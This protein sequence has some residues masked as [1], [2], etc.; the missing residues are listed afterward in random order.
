[1]DVIYDNQKKE[2]FVRQLPQCVANT[3]RRNYSRFEEETHKNIISNLPPGE[4]HQKII[5]EELSKTKIMLETENVKLINYTTKF[6]MEFESYVMRT[7][8]TI[9]NLEESIK[10]LGEG[11][12][13]EIKVSG[14]R[15]EKIALLNS[16]IETI[17]KKIKTEEIEHT[18]IIEKYNLSKATI[19]G[20]MESKKK[21]IVELM[22][23]I[24]N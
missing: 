2:I 15:N 7:N 11:Y 9:K 8:N 10:I 21:Q 4:K 12:V 1:M 6:A 20:L 14:K 13:G 5:L 17:Q 3:R 16:D 24:D 23:N 19:N 18:K 22:K